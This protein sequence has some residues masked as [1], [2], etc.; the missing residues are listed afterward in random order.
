MYSSSNMKTTVMG[1]RYKAILM[2]ADHT[3]LDF[4]AA[5]A[6]ALRA[7]F[8]RLG[9]RLAHDLDK[10][11]D[12]FRPEIEELLALEIVKRYYFQRG[13]VIEGL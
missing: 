4:E 9:E 2:D 8:D 5:E 13:E 3:L 11:L 7:L 1:M 10:D 12:T 6:R